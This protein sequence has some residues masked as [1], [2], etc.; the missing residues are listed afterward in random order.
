MRISSITKN[1]G[2]ACNNRLYRHIRTFEKIVKNYFVISPKSYLCEIDKLDTH[3]FRLL[4]GSER[5]RS[6]R[7]QIVHQTNI[8]LEYDEYKE[9]SNKE[10]LFIVL[11]KG[12][13]VICYREFMRNFVMEVVEMISS[14]SQKF[15][16]DEL[17]NQL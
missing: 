15:I 17:E 3:A 9:G 11:Y 8:K 1:A 7:D 14:I 2:K 13:I 5:G 6:L 4:C 10:K 12:E 16:L